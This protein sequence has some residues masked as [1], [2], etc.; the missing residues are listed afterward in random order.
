MAERYLNGKNKRV[1]VLVH[2]DSVRD[3]ISLKYED[4]NGMATVSSNT[5]KKGW[6]KLKD[7]EPAVVETSV[8]A[9]V[10]QHLDEEK[11]GDGTPYTQVMN[12]IL[13]DEKKSASKKKAK[14]TASKPKKAKKDSEEELKKHE[15]I[16]SHLDVIRS[17]L[18][19]YDGISYRIRERTPFLLVVSLNEETFFEVR[20][21]KEGATF[22]CRV[23]DVPEGLE[24]K[25]YRY[26]RPASVRTTDNYVEVLKS[27]IDKK[28]K[29]EN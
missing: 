23:V 25:E 24:Y 4:G 11:A 3:A 1:A 22:S 17:V 7:E 12:E 6:K 15:L 18:D 16:E 27:I 29:E 19:Q 14:T 5:L 26:Y 2:R 21:T 28:V 10:E 20:S 13:E 8:A 9:D